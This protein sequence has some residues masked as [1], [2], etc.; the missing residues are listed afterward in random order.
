MVYAHAGAAQLSSRSPNASARTARPRIL[1]A[2]A[3]LAALVGAATFAI[4]A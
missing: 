1:A 2:A 4:D 3:V